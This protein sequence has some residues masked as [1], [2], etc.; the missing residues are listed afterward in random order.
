MNTPRI[1][2]H[3]QARVPAGYRAQPSPS[4]HSLPPSPHGPHE[5]R[6]ANQRWRK[7]TRKHVRSSLTVA[8]D[9]DE[10]PGLELKQ[11]QGDGG[12]N[13]PHCTAAAHTC[14]RT[15]AAVAAP[16]WPRP[17]IGTA[18]GHDP[19]GHG[20]RGW[21]R[22]IK[23]LLRCTQG[24]LGTQHLALVYKRRKAGLHRARGK[25]G[26][27]CVRRLGKSPTTWERQHVLCVCRWRQCGAAGCGCRYGWHECG[28]GCGDG[29][30]GRGRGR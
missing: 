21:P 5:P 15:R 2:I 4:I 13:D 18:I 8:W 1:R 26:R 11:R 12:C 30:R 16:Y 17:L 10:S 6:V 24:G 20:W 3:A 7:H 27:L 22:V 14:T 28:R 9:G 29:W 23:E 19:I 25:R